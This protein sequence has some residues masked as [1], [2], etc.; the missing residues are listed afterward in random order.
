MV[1]VFYF[2]LVATPLAIPWA[3]TDWLWPTPWEWLLLLGVGVTTQTA[4][5]LMTQGLH[6]E[7]AGRATSVTYLQVAFAFVWG[8]AFFGESPTLF[9]G[10]G[11]ALVVCG[12]FAAVRARAR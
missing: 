3:M 10:L 2:P 4:Q 6:M 5:V 11:A 9:S 8:A 7:R 12:A 1:V